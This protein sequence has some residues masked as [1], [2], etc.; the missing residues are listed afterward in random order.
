MTNKKRLLERIAELVH[1]KKIDGI[2]DL[3]DESD[4][5]GMRVV[6]ELKR[7]EVPE[8]VLNN[9]Y[10]NTAMQTTSGI[11]F[12][13]IVNNK[14]EVSDLPTTLRHFAEHRKQNVRP[15]TPI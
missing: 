12:L 13:A 11:I 9:L 1:D 6:I 15:H 5:E 10:A 2:A 4:R 8:I 3:R 14:P 7:A